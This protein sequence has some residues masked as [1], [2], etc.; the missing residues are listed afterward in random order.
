MSITTKIFKDLRYFFQEA[1]ADPSK[2]R[3]RPQ[4]FTRSRKLPFS[5]MAMLMFSLLKK[6][7]RVN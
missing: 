6:V 1:G 3:K 5:T 4:D 2:Y 7:Y